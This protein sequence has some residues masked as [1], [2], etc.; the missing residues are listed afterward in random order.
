ML[1]TDTKEKNIVIGENKMF[2]L[3][4]QR[5]IDNGESG[6]IITVFTQALWVFN[7]FNFVMISVIFYQTNIKGLIPIPMW[8]Y[9][10]LIVIITAAWDLFFYLYLYPSIYIFSNKQ[11]FNPERNPM[12]R[13]LLEMKKDLEEMKQIMIGIKTDKKDELIGKKLITDGVITER[14]HRGVMELPAE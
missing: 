2:K 5:V 12:H 8:A 7:V 4:K 6:G 13:E 3:P 10:V 14:E 1:Y 9:F 11:T